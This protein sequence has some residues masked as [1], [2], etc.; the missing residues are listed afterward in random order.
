MSQGL[1]LPSGSRPRHEASNFSYR[2]LPHYPICLLEFYTMSHWE[3]WQRCFVW[4]G[5][6][7]LIGTVCP[8]RKKG[9]YQTLIV[10]H[11]AL[12]AH[13]KQT[14]GVHRCSAKAGTDKD[15]CNLVLTLNIYLYKPHPNVN[16]ER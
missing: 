10:Q 11:R 9:T 7:L 2:P 8:E 5:L 15:D 4:W 6:F 12:F 16:S 13:E 3:I 1:S 14:N